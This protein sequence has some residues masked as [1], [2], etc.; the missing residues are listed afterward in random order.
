MKPVSSMLRRLSSCSGLFAAVVLVSGLVLALPASVPAATFTF[1]PIDEPGAS[2][3]SAFGINAT[4]QIVGVFVNA[5]GEHG[6]LDAG[7]VFT[8]IDVPGATITDAS[9]IN[10]TGRI[11]GDFDDAAGT[12][13][14][15]ATPTA[16]PAPS[17]LLLLGTGLAFGAAWNRIRRRSGWTGHVARSRRGR[18]S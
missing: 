6:F 5:T 12:H 9:G 16:V 17:T 14:F 8:P 15:L 11:V 1:T 13:G 2:L 10:A 18:F 7:G 3:T 4:G